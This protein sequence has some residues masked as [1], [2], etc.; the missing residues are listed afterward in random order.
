MTEY[1]VRK[2]SDAQSRVPPTAP[3]SLQQHAVAVPTRPLVAH[4]SVQTTFRLVPQQN[5]IAIFA[6]CVYQEPT[7]SYYI[8]QKSINV[9]KLSKRGERGLSLEGYLSYS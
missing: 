2:P 6:A 3:Q 7:I 8:V 9:C 5:F 1:Q 4:R